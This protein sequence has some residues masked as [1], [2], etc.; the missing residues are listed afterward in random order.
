MSNLEKTNKLYGTNNGGEPI[1]PV[2]DGLTQMSSKMSTL[3]SND[4]GFLVDA[5]NIDWPSGQYSYDGDPTHIIQST[6]HLVEELR[7]KA[8]TTSL[9]DLRGTVDSLQ[10]RSADYYVVRYAKITKG[11]TPHGL[12]SSGNTAGNNIDNVDDSSI[13]YNDETWTLLPGYSTETATWM[14]SRKVIYVQSGSTY[15][16]QYDGDWSDPMK[17]TGDDGIAYPVHQVLLYKWTDS[18]NAPT[19]DVTSST[20]PGDWQESPGNASGNNIYLWMVQG[21]RQN[22]NYIKWD[23]NGDGTVGENEYWSTPICLSGPDGKTGEDGTDI[24]FIYKR[25]TSEQIFNDDNNNPN[26]WS[27]L[28]REGKITDN[29][30]LDPQRDDYLGP[31]NYHWN[32]NPEGVSSSYPYEYCSIRYKT[33]KV[34]SAFIPPFLWSKF[35]ENGLDGDGIEYIYCACNCDNINDLNEQYS[36]PEFNLNASGTGAFQKSE[37]YDGTNWHD[38]PQEVNETNKKYQWVSIRKFKKITDSN[39]TEI[40]SSF[41]GDSYTTID[42]ITVHVGD[43]IWFPYSQPELWNWY[44]NN[45]TNADRIVMLYKRTGSNTDYGNLPGHDE[46]MIYLVT[47]NGWVESP[48][49]N[50]S[51]TT[52]DDYLWMT[53]NYY[54]KKEIRGTKTFYTVT[55]EWSTPVCLTGEPGHD[56]ED[57]SDIEFIYFRTAND[58]ADIIVPTKDDNFQN[59]DWPF[60][61]TIGTNYYVT[62]DGIKT[63]LNQDHD[64]WTDNPLGV[65]STYDYEY[66][67]VRRKPAGNNS[68]WGDFSKPFLWSKYGEDGVDGDGVEYIFYRSSNANEVIFSEE[69]NNLPP[70]FDLDPNAFQK[71]EVLGNWTDDPQGVNETNVWEYVSVRKFREITNSNLNDIPESFRNQVHVGD[72]IWFPYSEPALWS[73]YAFDAVAS[74]LTIETDNDMM[75]VAIDGQNTTRN[76]SSNSAQVFLYHNLLLLSSDKYDVSIVSSNCNQNWLT[77]TN[78]DNKWKITIDIPEDTLLPTDGSFNFTI[79]AKVK[80]NN[81]SIPEEIRDAERFYTFKVIGLSLSTIYQ[82]KTDKIVIH[83]DVNN[84]LDNV[85]VTMFNI[86]DINDTFTTGDTL[87]ENFYIFA[88]PTRVSKSPDLT[89]E[90][91]YDDSEYGDIQFLKNGESFNIKLYTAT[92]TSQTI[93]TSVEFNLVYTTDAEDKQRIID[94]FNSSSGTSGA[95]QPHYGGER[96]IT[97]GIL[98]D[99]ET[100][101]VISDGAKGNPGTDSKSQEYIYFVTDDLSYFESTSHNSSNPSLW[102]INEEVI[103]NGTAYY[104]YNTD[105]FPFV[106]G[107]TSYMGWEDT[108]IGISKALSY[109]FTST[110]SYDTSTKKWGAFSEP[111]CT[112]NWGHTGEDGDG[113]EYIY[114]LSSTLFPNKSIH[115]QLNPAQWIMCWYDE[116]EHDYEEFQQSEYIPFDTWTDNPSNVS[117][118]NS[119]EYVS[120]R[121]YKLY[122]ANNFISDIKST[123]FVSKDTDVSM[124]ITDSDEILTGL[125]NHLLEYTNP[126]TSRA[127]VF[128]YAA[129]YCTNNNLT[130]SSIYAAVDGTG[131]GDKSNHW[132]YTIL[133]FVI[134]SRNSIKNNQKVWC[135]YSYPTLWAKYGEDGQT[136]ADSIILDFT[137]DQIN[138]AVSSAGYIKTGQTR[139]TRLNVI[140]IGT[141]TISTVALSS[142]SLNHVEVNPNKM[143]VNTRKI[144][145]TYTIYST[146]IDISLSSDD[147]W[148]TEKQIPENGLEIEF[149]VTLSG[150]ITLTKKLNICGQHNGEDGDPAVTYEIIPTVNAIYKNGS[151]FTPSSISYIVNKYTGTSVSTVSDSEFSNSFYAKWG[152]LANGSAAIGASTV[153][154]QNVPYENSSSSAIGASDISY[155]N[156][157][158]ISNSKVIDRETIPI[159]SK[160]DRGYDGNPGADAYELDW[161][162]DQINFGVN[163]DGTIAVGQDGLSRTARLQIYTVD[164][165]SGLSISSISVDSWNPSLHTNV[166]YSISGTQVTITLSANKTVTIPENGWNVTFNVNVSKNGNVIASGIR[167]TLKIFGQRTGQNGVSYEIVPSVNAIYNENDITINPSSISYVV[168]KYDGTQ[169][170]QNT[171]FNNSFKAQWTNPN[172]NSLGYN[173]TISSTE[174]KTYSY[175]NLNL[176]YGSGTSAKVIDRETIPI[177]KK[178]EPGSQGF[179]GPIV[180]MRGQ[181]IKN[182]N[183]QYG[184]GEYNKSSDG[185]Q[186]DGVSPLYK[187]IVTYTWANGTTKYYTPK[188]GVGGTYIGTSTTYLCTGS[189]FVANTWPANPDGTLNGKWTVAQNFDFIATKLLYADQALINQISTHDLIATKQNG[190]PVAGITSGSKVMKDKEG[191]NILSPLNPSNSNNPISSPI[192][193]SGS[194]DNPTLNSGDTD[195]SS[196]RIFAGEIKKGNNYS[197]TYA[198]FNVRQDGTAYMTKAVVTGDIT[199]NTLSLGTGSFAYLPVNATSGIHLPNLG[200]GSNTRSFYILSSCNGNT[201]NYI[202]IGTVKNSGD[203]I[204]VSVGNTTIYT[205]SSSFDNYIFPKANT[206]Y[207]CI[208]IGKVWNIIINE[209]TQTTQGVEYQYIDVTKDVQLFGYKYENSN[210]KIIPYTSQIENDTDIA[211]GPYLTD[212]GTSIDIEFFTYLDTSHYGTST[213]DYALA[214]FGE[215]YWM[216]EGT[217]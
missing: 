61:G 172:G 55:D 205:S 118:E 102:N 49:N 207:Q 141:R 52:N 90:Q 14:T 184:N 48:G 92:D 195:D 143:S 126:S 179:T 43:K 183:T 131:R 202:R 174:Y 164:S 129:T 4:P 24:E 98:V 58:N 38:D 62:S 21:R 176:W 53:S 116:R 197:L 163:Y 45:G 154:I 28:A 171:S 25:F 30:Y 27:T 67:A 113:V 175:I 194:S 36:V 13:I 33:N 196:V 209:L 110:R 206:L 148:G 76:A 35:G 108:Q 156:L 40:S 125:F 41:T 217:N 139:S 34:W 201:S 149:T 212:N 70:A 151:T 66:A 160:G 146:Y 3:N 162:N 11:T 109:Q 75:A 83:R 211:F 155:I 114:Y 80:N 193:N 26:H 180:R 167:K 16:K 51:S 86:S 204:N 50:T 22:S 60:V 18:R 170:T 199:A 213:S 5:F 2:V 46:N 74:N 31:V 85:N 7:G 173:N 178:G 138:L 99:R 185:N 134:K 145:L 64:T 128:N 168:Y 111:V 91:N 12:P 63:L 121:K 117:E 140:N 130:K 166:T 144:K 71:P 89:L 124:S 182:S 210:V 1:V 150:S 122:N 191:N 135:P 8:S 42:N 88:K 159:V 23:A 198:P 216:T 107:Q 214:D 127:N 54:S 68:E 123:V 188:T 189:Y 78:T 215:F 112:H 169:I 153:A 192:T 187:D 17:M 100:V 84:E 79:K 73:K 186:Y 177:I 95:V 82:L 119:Y 69:N 132:F 96:L 181:V 39:K 136:G 101:S 56:G 190:Y 81:T 106:N 147:D 203:T 59:N 72:K 152:E 9:E 120:V 44:V 19:V 165:N 87:P 142:A 105:D 10:T 65:T 29:N 161:D 97:H 94:S 104:A 157:E 47:T 57:G 77:I 103:I 115:N 137:N 6:G 20:K 32:D 208:S 158:L 37:V 93:L 15:A 133:Y 200:D